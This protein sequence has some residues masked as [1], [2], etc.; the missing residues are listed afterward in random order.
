MSNFKVKSNKFD[1]NVTAHLGNQKY[2]TKIISGDKEIIGDEP[3]FLG[4]NNLGFN[5]YEFL[6]S[7]LSMCTAATL[8]QY[9]NLKNLDVGE[10]SVNVNFSN[11]AMEKIATFT[12]EINFENQELDEATLT[13]LKRVAESCPVNKLLTNEIVVNTNVKGVS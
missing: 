12:K 9:T 5:P 8:R 11:N 7:A 3:E 10:I 6:A 13:T 1:V 2:L 4:G